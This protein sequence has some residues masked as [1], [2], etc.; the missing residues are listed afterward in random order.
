MFNQCLDQAFDDIPQFAKVVDDGLVFT[1]TFLSQVSTTCKV[2]QEAREHGITLSPHKF[3]F[4]VP[5]VHFCG[6][7]ISRSGWTPDQDKAAPSANFPEPTNHTDLRSFLGLINQCS[8]LNSSV[9]QR[10]FMMRGLLKTSNEF[11]WLPDHSAAMNALRQALLKPPTLGFFDPEAPTCLKDGCV[12][13]ERSRFSHVATARLH[14]VPDPMRKSIHFRNR[15]SL[16]YDRA[17]DVRRCLGCLQI[18]TYLAGLQFNLIVDHQPLV[19]ILNTYTLDQVENLRLQRLLQKVYPYQ[20]PISWQRGSR[21]ASA[22]AVSC[23]PVDDPSPRDELGKDPN[24]G[25]SVSLCLQKDEHHADTAL[26]MSYHE[27]YEAALADQDYQDGF[28]KSKYQLSASLQRFWNG[29]EHLS[30]DNR[31]VLRGS[32]LVIPKGLRQRVL[33]DLHSS[34]QGM[35]RTKHRARQTVFWPNLNKDVC[36]TVSACQQCGE[37]LPWQAK[38]PLRHK[39]RPTLPFEHASA[40]V[41][42]C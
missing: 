8:E 32:R 11:V 27:V 17:R 4:A 16:R 1:D 9:A 36:K 40:D 29:H 5:K 24:H 21:H 2:L 19:P 14:M 41:F 37:Y 39:P 20:S 15:V 28:P 18:H 3:E 34:H 26:G 31:I 6:Y 7:T 35:E 10:A 30:T 13:Y 12:L 33:T 25:L 22:D 38:E 42:S 23:A